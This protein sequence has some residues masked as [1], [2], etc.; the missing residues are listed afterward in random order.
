MAL[1]PFHDSSDSGFLSLT[2]T[3]GRRGREKMAL[4]L[5][6]PGVVFPSEDRANRGLVF[7][8]LTVPS[9]HG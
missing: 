5:V 7:T 6:P 3:C 2:I 1:V 4:G 9:C 8:P